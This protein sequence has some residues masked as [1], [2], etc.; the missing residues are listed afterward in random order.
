MHQ[1]MSLDQALPHFQTFLHSRN[2][3]SLTQQVYNTDIQQFIAWLKETTVIELHA[4]TITKTDI[5]EYLAYLADLGRSGVTRARKLASI[6]EFFRYLV[7]NDRIPSS[8]AASVAIP[9]KERKQQ[10]YLRPDEY[11]RL[12]SAA[13][14]HPRD[15]AMLQS[16]L[17]T[18]IRVSELVSLTLQAIDMQARTILVAGKGKKERTI[19]LEKKGILAL[20]N[21]LATRP[22]S[23]DPHLFLNYNGAGI[24]RRGAEK[25]IEKYRALSG[26]TK[27]FSCHSLRHTFGSYKAT[28]GV[29]PFQLKEWMGHSSIATTQIYVHMGQEGAKKA[30]EATSL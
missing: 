26:I 27:R 7:E 3:S 12:L 11:A 25:I 1:H 13:G 6:R 29:S 5:N 19:S 20:K 8:P 22:Q 15:F 23:L 24:S 17:Q 18:G 10:T 28:L 21:Y 30:M 2:T 14:S 4:G 16:L 9:R